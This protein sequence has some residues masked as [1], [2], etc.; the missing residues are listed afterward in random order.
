MHLQSVFR[1]LPGHLTQQSFEIPDCNLRL[2]FE[3]CS[4]IFAIGFQNKAASDDP[5]L[6][7]KNKENNFFLIYSEYLISSLANN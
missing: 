1:T 7:E 5:E 4:A 3:D 2:Q 6:S